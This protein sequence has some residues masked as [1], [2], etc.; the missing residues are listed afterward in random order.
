MAQI[1]D[2][3]YQIDQS[4]PLRIITRRDEEGLEN[5]PAF[6]CALAGPM[7]SSDC[8]RKRKGDDRTGH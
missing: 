7:Q 4:G 3:S 8:F 2:T 1:H 5:H 6:V